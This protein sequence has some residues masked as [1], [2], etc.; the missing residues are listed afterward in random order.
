MS[1]DLAETKK[2]PPAS[3]P[4]AGASKIRTLTRGLKGNHLGSGGATGGRLQQHA[5][6]VSIRMR[7]VR[8]SAIALTIPNLASGIEA[9]NNFSLHE[10]QIVHFYNMFF[11]NASP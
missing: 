9:V 1:L 11:R 7:D 8:S 4:P 2:R 10:R 6:S 5:S 3:F